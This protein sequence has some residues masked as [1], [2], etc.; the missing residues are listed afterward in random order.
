MAVTNRACKLMRDWVDGPLAREYSLSSDWDNR[1]RTGGTVDEVM[2]EAHL[3]PDH[4]FEAIER[5]AAD[6]AERHD[7]CAPWSMPS[8]AGREARVPELRPHP[9]EHQRPRRPAQPAATHQPPPER[10][11]PPDLRFLIYVGI[12]LA[13]VLAALA[14]PYLIGYLLQ[15]MNGG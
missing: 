3:G 9:Y 6:R 5:Y 7:G 2:D 14:T 12:A 13:A 1:W 15:A 10:Q 8:T 4:I 11:S